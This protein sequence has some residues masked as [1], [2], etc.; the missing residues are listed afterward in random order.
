[1]AAECRGTVTHLRAHPSVVTWVLFNEGWGQFDALACAEE[2]HLLDPT[3]PIDAVS[4]WYDQG[5][6]RLPERAPTISVRLRS[7]ATGAT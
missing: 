2:V 4:G 7:T 5:A 6:G 3:R 1:M